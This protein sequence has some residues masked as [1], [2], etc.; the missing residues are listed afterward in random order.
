MLKENITSIKKCRLCNC[1]QLESIIDFGSVALG[2]NLQPT[3]NLSKNVESFTLR[4]NRCKKCNHF[5]LGDSVSPELL[6][7]TNYTYLSGIG[8]SFVKHIDNYASWV[9]AKTKIKKNDFVVDVGSNDGT[10]LKAFKKNGFKVCGI[11][12][13]KIAANIANNV[14][15]YTINDFFSK[16]VIK[17]IIEKFGKADFITSQNV[18]A[19]IEN[20]REI[21]ENIYSLLKDNAYFAFE[22]GYFRKV[23]ELNCFDT[24]YHEHL[25]YHHAYPLSIFLTS[26]GFEIVDLSINDIQGGSLR[27][28]LKKSHDPKVSK[29]AQRFIEEEKK[30]LLY[31]AL[32]IKNWSAIIEDNMKSLRKIIRKN[33]S[34]GKLTIAYGAPTKIVLLLKMA[35]LNSNDIKFIIEDN[36]EKV[37]KFLPNTGIQIKSIND[38]TKD[39]K[40]DILIAA[41]NFSNDIIK[42]LKGHFNNEIKIII[43]IPKMKVI[44]I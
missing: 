39:F 27:V 18:L 6:Y 12:P 40:G 44:K 21:F 3:L 38:L 42:K 14:G 10:C 9:I 7:A 17:I 20:P 28:L 16:K 1:E 37:G 4:V 32:F 43:P 35:Q 23:V 15:I 30:S 5:Q 31:D 41:W 29:Q 26:I 8:K 22:V 13:A 36:D 2:N 24:I 34:E 25:D 33:V 19:H 11:D